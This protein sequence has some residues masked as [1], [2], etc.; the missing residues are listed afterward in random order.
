MKIHGSRPINILLALIY[1][2]QSSGLISRG[3]FCVIK[4][5]ISS[6]LAPLSPKKEINMN[7][8][9]M[10]Y[11]ILAMAGTFACHGQELMLRI[12]ETST[13]SLIKNP[14][15]VALT[16]GGQIVG[17]IKSISIQKGKLLDVT[18]EMTDKTIQKLKPKEIE[19][20]KIR[21]STPVMFT[22]KDQQGNDIKKVVYSQY[23]FE[24]P[25][26]KSG[27]V[28]PDVMQLLNPGFDSKL[29]IYADLTSSQPVSPILNSQGASQ[30]IRYVIVVGEKIFY[31]NAQSYPRDFLRLFGDCDVMNSM[32]KDAD[33]SAIAVHTLLYDH[34]CRSDQ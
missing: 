17:T 31:T 28:K 3:I 10:R 29:K 7:L 14:A 24:H 9:M 25:F 34:Y 26:Q 19:S 4:T 13:T 20:L 5:K 15:V 21:S 23:I 6:K 2:I 27:K 11:L 1:H 22:L 32:S 18:I 8:V 12:D 30:E 33:I 16:S